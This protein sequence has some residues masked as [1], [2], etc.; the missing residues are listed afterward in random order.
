MLTLNTASISILAIGYAM[1]SSQQNL[2]LCDD[3]VIMQYRDNNTFIQ[4]TVM[5]N[6][7]YILYIL[8]THAANNDS[9]TIITYAT[10]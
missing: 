5:C 1:S 7:Y 10:Y 2:I 4:Y 9:C 6:K 3:E 8:L